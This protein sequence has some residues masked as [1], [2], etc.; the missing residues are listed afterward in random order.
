MNIFVTGASGFIG[1]AV[2]TQ[3]QRAAHAVPAWPGPSLRRTVCTRWAPTFFDA[4]WR[5]CQP[6]KPR[7]MPPTESSTLVSATAIPSSW[8]STP[9]AR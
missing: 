9:T 1:T 4:H 2:V 5:I 3:L 8:R 7:P 6:C